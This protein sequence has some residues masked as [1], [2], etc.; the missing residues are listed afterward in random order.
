M[1]YRHEDELAS[2]ITLIARAWGDVP[3]RAGHAWLSTVANRIRRRPS[4]LSILPRRYWEY[5]RASEQTGTAPEFPLVGCA[6]ARKPRRPGRRGRMTCAHTVR[7]RGLVEYFMFFLHDISFCQERIGNGEWDYAIL[8]ACPT[9][10]S[11]VRIARCERSQFI[12]C[13]SQ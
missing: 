5:Y 9:V 7:C 11:G 13:S 4:R 12:P 3:G 1:R 2:G 6:S 10:S 8:H